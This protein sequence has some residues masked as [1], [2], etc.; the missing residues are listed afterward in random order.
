MLQ[1]NVKEGKHIDK[2]TLEKIFVFSLA[3]SMAGLCE[4]EDR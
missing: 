1:K 2:A 3:W 4:D